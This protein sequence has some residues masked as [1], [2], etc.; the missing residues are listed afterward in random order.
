MYSLCRNSA[1]LLSGRSNLKFFWCVR[2]S[3]LGPENKEKSMCC[4]AG[5]PPAWLPDWQCSVSSHARKDFAMEIRSWVMIL[6]NKSRTKVITHYCFYHKQRHV[7]MLVSSY[8]RLCRR[9]VYSCLR[10]ISQTPFHYYNW[11]SDARLIM[12][13]VCVC[14]RLSP[15]GQC[16]DASRPWLCFWIL[17]SLELLEEHIPAVVAS[18]WVTHAHRLTNSHSTTRLLPKRS[19]INCALPKTSYYFLSLHSSPDYCNRANADR[20][21]TRG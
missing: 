3:P 5:R 11:S 14:L 6:C 4:P 20:K 19:Q 9:L 16:L 7:F 2:C 18:E 21:L 1:R 15:C 8:R 10:L 12:W 13:C 17:H